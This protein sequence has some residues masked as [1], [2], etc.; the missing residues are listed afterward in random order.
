MNHMSPA[1]TVSKLQ[2]GVVTGA[3]YL[4]LL[5]ACRDGGYALP[6]VNVVGTNSI[7]AVLE[8]AARSAVR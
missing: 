6:A 8:A 2:P 7:N 4:T 1:G 3:D 5:Q